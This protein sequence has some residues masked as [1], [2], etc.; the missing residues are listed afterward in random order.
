LINKTLPIILGLG[1]SLPWGYAFGQAVGI[2]GAG[3]GV[4]YF[5]VAIQ[6]QL[7]VL[8]A[9]LRVLLTGDDCTAPDFLD[10]GTHC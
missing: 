3:T 1:A 4:N 2:I 7:T 9:Q 5:P 10:T 8:E 6:Q